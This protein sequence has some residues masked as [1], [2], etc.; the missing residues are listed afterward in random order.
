[1]DGDGIDDR[2]Q[3]PGYLAQVTG[4]MQQRQP[5]M[6]EQLLGGGGGGGGGRGGMLS[7]PLAKAT[8][9]GVAAMAVKKMTGR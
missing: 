7:N 1:L 6:L 2:L 5:G 9:A 3:D 4:G 8:L